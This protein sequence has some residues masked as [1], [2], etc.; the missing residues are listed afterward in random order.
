MQSDMETL[1]VAF[2]VMLYSVSHGEQYLGFILVTWQVHFHSR[3]LDKQDVVLQKFAGLAVNSAGQ[4]DMSD[5]VVQHMIGF[6][7]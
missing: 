4:F 6:C 7:Y 2:A 3:P 5:E 1:L